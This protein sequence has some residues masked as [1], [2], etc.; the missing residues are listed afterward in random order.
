MFLLAPFVEPWIALFGA[1]LMITEGYRA[2]IQDVETPA[3]KKG[4][5]R[6]AA[7]YAPIEKS[8]EE[9][10]AKAKEE[11][12]LDCAEY[13]EIIRALS[14]EYEKLVQYDKELD[15]KLKNTKIGDTK[16]AWGDLAKKS[17]SS[18]EESNSEPLG[19]LAVK[20]ASYASYKDAAETLGLSNAI[21]LESFGGILFNGGALKLSIF[22]FFEHHRDMKIFK[23]E[24]AGYMEAKEKFIQCIHKHKEDFDKLK[25]KVTD[26]LDKYEQLCIDIILVINSLKIKIA[27]KELLLDID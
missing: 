26:N 18:M 14:S 24:M 3:K 21:S 15:E 5:K 7:K 27:E 22:G 16:V 12:K 25:I 9:M 23:S 6:A 19:G 11:H 13:T 10:I 1:D 8:I 20:S 2:F 17:E 4:Y